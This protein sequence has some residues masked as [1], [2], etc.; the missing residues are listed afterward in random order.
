MCIIEQT[1]G[2]VLMHF[3]CMKR[4][5]L[6]RKRPPRQRLRSNALVLTDQASL[7]TFAQE[8]VLC[9]K[10][11]RMHRFQQIGLSFERKADSPIYCKR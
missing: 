5:D 9:T 4:N 1:W 3:A 2:C 11:A 6:T 8:I 10:C 7:C